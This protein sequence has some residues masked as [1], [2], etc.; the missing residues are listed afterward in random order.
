MA[1]EQKAPSCDPLN[2]I[3]SVFI[4]PQIYCRCLHICIVLVVVVVVLIYLFF[5]LHYVWQIRCEI[6]IS[7]SME[8]NEYMNV[9]D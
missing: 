7:Y 8:W 3:S 1:Y 2:H 4:A 5:Y 9:F 6:S